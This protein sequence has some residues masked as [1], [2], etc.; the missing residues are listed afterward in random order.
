MERYVGQWWARCN[1]GKA[2]SF[3]FLPVSLHLHRKMLLS[4]RY[5]EVTS[6]I[7]IF[8][9]YDL[10]QENIRKTFLAFM[11]C[12]MERSESH[13]CTWQFS[14]SFSLKFLYVKEPCFRVVCSE[15][16]HREHLSTENKMIL[17]LKIHWRPRV[18]I[19]FNELVLAYLS[20]LCW[21]LTY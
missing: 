16:Y 19:V 21:F 9:F 20:L 13:F 10:L 14:D 1:W 2:C 4:L 18:T 6:H 5:R 3:Q 17:T 8:F 11:T 15:L 12:H 7:M